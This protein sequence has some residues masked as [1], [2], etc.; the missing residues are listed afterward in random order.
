VDTISQ[1][2]VADLHMELELADHMMVAL[3]DM[4]EVVMVVIQKL[5]MLFKTPEV[6]AVDLKEQVP[7]Q[8]SVIMVDM[9]LPVLFSL[10]ILPNK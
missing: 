1:V 4:E 10:H 9:V 5:K 2:A 6:V 8:T 3:V 7:L